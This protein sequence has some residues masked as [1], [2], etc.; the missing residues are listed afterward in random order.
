MTHRPAILGCVS[1]AWTTQAKTCRDW[2]SRAQ[3]CS[4][5][6]LPVHHHACSLR[7]LHSLRSS[8]RAPT[9]IQL[10]LRTPP[11]LPIPP[12]PPHPKPHP[13]PPRYGGDEVDLTQGMRNWLAYNLARASGRYASRTAWAEVFLLDDGAPALAPSH[14]HGMYITL[15]VRLHFSLQLTVQPGMYVF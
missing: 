10:C 13:L 5:F 15:E 7:S 2:P 11:P 14:Y 1:P 8:C 4:L 9:P 6:L 3:E 12:P